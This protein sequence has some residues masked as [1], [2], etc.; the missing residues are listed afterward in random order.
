LY[1]KRTGEETRLCKIKD[2]KFLEKNE[3]KFKFVTRDA[4]LLDSKLNKSYQLARIGPFTS[5]ATAN[6]WILSQ[7]GKFGNLREDNYMIRRKNTT[8]K[9]IEFVPFGENYPKNQGLQGVAVTMQKNGNWKCSDKE[10]EGCWVVNLVN[11]DHSWE[12]KEEAS[13]VIEEESEEMQS[14]REQVWTL[15]KDLIART[16]N[17]IFTR[18]EFL[19]KYESKLEKQW[20]TKNVGQNISRIFQELRDEG[21]ITFLDDKGTYQLA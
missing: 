9:N 1:Y 13:E 21:K 11:L 2:F 4:L 5:R 6:D 20:K 18:K 15:C 12:M 7:K 10:E 17:I 19:E 3:D 8:E 16:G 14:Q